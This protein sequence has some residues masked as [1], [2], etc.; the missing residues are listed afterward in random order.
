ML[1]LY[2]AELQSEEEEEE[3]GYDCDDDDDDC[4]DDD[5]DEDDDD[6]EDEDDD[7]E[8]DDDE[9]DDDDDEDNY[10][11]GVRATRQ[12]RQQAQDIALKLSRSSGLY[13]EFEGLAGPVDDTSP[14]SNNA[15]DYLKLVWPQMLCEMLAHETNRY[16]SQNRVP[17]WR[18]TTATEMWSFL[19]AVLLMGIHVLPRI[20]NYW[21]Q[22]KFLGVEALSR[23]FTRDRFRAL[24]R[25]LHVVDNENANVQD[26]LYKVRPLI[27]HLQASFPACYHPSQELAVDEAMVKCK[28]RAKGK[29]YMPKKP[30]KRGFKIWCCSCSCCGYLCTFDVYSGRETNPRTGRPV[31]EV[32]QLARVVKELVQP[33]E[34]E[35]HVLYCD[36]LYT[37]GPIADYLA[38]RK[39]YLVGTIRQDARGFPESLKACVPRKGEYR[40]TSVGNNQYFV[41]HD[42]KVVR[43]I[44]NVFPASMEQ[45]VP[46][47]QSQG[48]LV[49]RSVPPLL[50]AYNKYMGGV[51]LTGQLQCYY[52]FDRKCRRPW[53]RV[54]FHLFGFAVNNAH[55]LYKHNCRKVGVKSKD[56]LAFRLELVHLLLDRAVGRKRQRVIGH[57]T[58]HNSR[59]EC[60]LVS[61]SEAGLKRGRCTH[62]LNTKDKKDRCFTSYACGSCCVRL[63]KVHCF[64]AY[65]RHDSSA[66]N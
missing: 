51:D 55:I 57:E 16:A 4:D 32:G 11:V 15:L 20:T 29:V 33:Y 35:N 37:N 54:F 10:S 38:E 30:V 26:R 40:C 48:I 8:E 56:L 21:S 14:I 52:A 43:F 24:L 58:G 41:Y 53:L 28:G 13:P 19:G 60:G 44:T 49:E 47:L 45:K 5:E 66:E 62:C 1:I 59:E 27:R 65:H 2:F 6:D 46:V 42:R 12:K 31:S 9:D 22:D 61:V 36:S 25:N 34:G 63:C 18:N 3:E 23:C 64:A 39:V 7:D 50:P 17:H